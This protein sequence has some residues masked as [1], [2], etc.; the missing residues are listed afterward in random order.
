M[1]HP[2]HF[3]SDNAS[4]A[5]PKVLKALAAASKEHVGSYGDD[6]YTDQATGFLKKTFG[7]RVEPFFVFGGTGANVTAIA[8]V[9]KPFQA[10]ICPTVAHVHRSECGALERFAGVKILAVHTEDGKLTPG[11]VGPLLGD[12][13]D[14]HH[15][16]PAVV[17]I[18][19]PNEL[20]LIYSPGEIA[21]L[22]AF[23]RSR[24]LLL[25]MDGA[26][27]ANAAAAMGCSPAQTSFDLG[28]DV[29]SFGGTK[30]G[31]VFGEVVLFA[32][33]ALAKD[34]PYVRKQAMQLASKMRFIAAQYTVYLAG[35]LWRENAQKA[36]AMARLLAESLKELPQIRLVRPV[37]TNAVFAVIPERIVKPLK[38][39]FPFHL[40]DPASGEARLMTSWDHEERHIRDFVAAAADAVRA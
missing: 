23:C 4:G 36:N 2:I 25:H 34:A 26:R 31:L 11:L 39:R 16:Q 27:L 17:S 22:S 29:L 6:P 15:A 5:H 9:A 10:L 1:K 12:K 37:E 13:G 21:D 32:D 19:Q 40:W 24:G 35:E 20:G 18:S 38:T 3:S 7:K 28:V 8:S 33:P 14:P 30:N